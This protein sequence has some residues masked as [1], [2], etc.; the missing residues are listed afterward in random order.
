M[1]KNFVRLKILFEMASG[2]DKIQR[3][4]YLTVWNMTL[5]GTIED[6][7]TN[8]FISKYEKAFLGHGVFEHQ[9]YSAITEAQRG[10]LKLINVLKT[11]W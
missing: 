8:S 1:S 2:K 3:E 10:W 4:F 6:S 11:D 7:Y 5:M 9:H